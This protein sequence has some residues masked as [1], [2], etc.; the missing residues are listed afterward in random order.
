MS[1]V[2]LKDEDS[3]LQ[4]PRLDFRNGFNITLVFSTDSDNGILLYSGVDQHMAVELFRGRIRVSYDVGNYPVSTMFRYVLVMIP[5]ACLEEL[6]SVSML[7]NNNKI[8]H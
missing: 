2:T 3:Y 7:T 8:C 5:S 4:F 6:A 1:S